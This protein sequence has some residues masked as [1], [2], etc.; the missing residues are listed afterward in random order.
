MKC[1]CVRCGHEWESVVEKPRVCPR[2]KS[3]EFD[4]PRKR[5]KGVK[6]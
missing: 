5:G 4:K 3:Y 2:C 1:R 6:R